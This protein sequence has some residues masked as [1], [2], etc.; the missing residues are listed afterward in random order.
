MASA[1]QGTTTQEA[2]AAKGADEERQRER[3]A[4][5]DGCQRW[6]SGHGR[7][8]L[9]ATMEALAAEAGEGETDDVYGS[10]ALI[11]DFEHEVAG[12][13]SKEAAVF[14]PS[15]TMA[16]QIALRI[17]S[18]RTGRNVV[19]FHPTC[20]LEL[21]EEHGYQ[22]LHGLRARLV[23]ESHRL[24]T[25][26]DLSHV[27]EPVAALLLE[28][29]QREIGGQLPEW[30]D[31][32]AQTAW[33]RERGAG[34]HMDGARLWEAAPYYGRSYAEVA[35]LFDTVYVSFYKGIGGISG[36]MLLGP[37]EFVT[38]AR[39]WQRRHGGNLRSLAPYV[40]A[41]RHGLRERLG[42]FAAYH[43]RALAIARAL[44]PLPGILLK[45]DPPQTHMMHVYLRGDAERL[46]D[47]IA[48][49]AREERVALARGLRGCELP[50]YCMFELSVG[51]AAFALSDDE[52]AGY[53][54]RVMEQG[55]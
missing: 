7:L 47:A 45:P 37:A 36:A 19:A 40:L 23:G 21:H 28:L 22:R 48:A 31:L 14:M 32:V 39:A 12:L 20:H 11:E 30:D 52:I 26:D 24:L 35:A 10:G 1:A 17:W 44:S 29:P 2:A 15:G 16:Q 3:R 49:I 18:E 5:F 33:A 42:R 4:I 34:V 54:R 6:L 13:L 46:M 50:G 38:E 9:R 41:A 43:E 51:D 55:R 8:S 25:L 53:F 27:A